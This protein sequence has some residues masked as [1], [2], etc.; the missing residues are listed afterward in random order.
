M[1]TTF[2]TRL[3]Q[4]CDDSG[5]IPEYG[6]GRQVVIANRLSVTQEAVRKWFAGEALPRPKKM[7][8][9]A[10]FLDVEEPWLALGVKPEMDRTAKRKNLA[11]LDGAVH[12]V[13]G[14]IMLE[15]GSVGF[16]RPDDPRSAHVDLYAIMR[17]AQMA[18]H[19][20]MA[21]E[22]SKGRFS[23]PIPRNY[24]D[25][26]CIGVVRV[27]VGKFHFLNLKKSLIEEHKVKQSGDY[28]VSAALHDGKYIIGSDVWPRFKTFGELND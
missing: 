2:A 21:R 1:E 19:V 22:Q 8:E 6:K 25:V 15:G 20:C 10:E 5:T 26:K 23:F 11:A 3:Q 28:L 7:K 17:G 12:V 27:G 24:P 9:L 16:P 14:L 18:L 4:A 13:S